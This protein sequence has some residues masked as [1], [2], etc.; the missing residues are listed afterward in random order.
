MANI[1]RNNNGSFSITPGVYKNYFL[2]EPFEYSGYDYSGSQIVFIANELSP[3]KLFMSSYKDDSFNDNPNIFIVKPCEEYEYVLTHTDNTFMMCD[4]YYDGT[5]WYGNDQR[6]YWGWFRNYYGGDRV[7]SHWISLDIDGGQGDFYRL[8]EEAKNLNLST[9][10]LFVGNSNN[11]NNYIIDYR[12]AAFENGYL[13][14]Y[15]KKY[16]Y[17]YK[18]PEYFGDPCYCSKNDGGWVLDHISYMGV[19][20]VYPN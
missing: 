12:Q 3:S 7:K 18:C 14:K 20:E 17:W 10:W 13:R 2:D 1:K 9:I 16:R 11:F 5:I 6:D 4:Q 15:M 8:F 19:F